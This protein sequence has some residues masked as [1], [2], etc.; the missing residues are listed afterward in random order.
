M[1]ETFGQRIDIDLTAGNE[2][3]RLCAG[4]NAPERL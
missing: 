2:A 3:K 1:L 4:K